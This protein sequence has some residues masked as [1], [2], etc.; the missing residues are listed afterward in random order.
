M[1]FFLNKTKIKFIKSIQIDWTKAG[2][3][4]QF[5][6][7][8]TIH[9][10]PEIRIL[11]QTTQHF[12]LFSPPASRAHWFYK[13]HYC[14]IKFNFLNNFPSSWPAPLTAVCPRVFARARED[15][16]ERSRPP[17]LARGP[18]PAKG[19]DTLF[20]LALQL[21]CWRYIFWNVSHFPGRRLRLL[22]VMAFRGVMLS[23]VSYWEC[24]RILKEISLVLENM[25]QNWM[26]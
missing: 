21:G 13:S 22:A 17:S 11:L 15:S 24:W 26:L 8:K 6:A 19:D 23:M 14:A 2:L 4:M 3:K 20:L 10:N 18:S 16:F 9:S 7:K 1:S 12:F 5:N 25:I